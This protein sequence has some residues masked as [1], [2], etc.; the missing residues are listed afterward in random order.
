MLQIPAIVEAKKLGLYVIAVDMNSNAEGFSYA[1]KKIVVSTTDTEKVLEEAKKNKIDG[2]ITI[3]SDRPMTTVAKVAKELDLIGIDEKT[4]INATNKSKMRDALKAYG[5]PIPMYF[6]VEDYDQYIKAID[7]LRNKKY[8]CIVKP[9][10]NSGSRGIRLVEN[11]DID[12]LKK[13]YDYCKKN[14]NSGKL[15]IEEYMQGPEVSVETI[16]RNGTCNVIQITDKLTTGAPY[17]VEMGHNQPSQLPINIIEKIKKVAIDANKAVGIE[18]GPSHTEIKVTKDGPKIVELGAR[19]GGDNITTHLVPYSTGI[20]M[21]EASIKIALGEDVDITKKI[22]MASAARYKKCDIGKIIKITGVD[23][24]NKIQGVK[25][26]KIVHGVGEE[27]RQIKSSNDRV[28]YVISQAENTSKATL[29]CEK[30][31]EKIKIEVEK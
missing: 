14:S 18:N 16:S 24:A 12:Q 22:N 3:A 28:A 19:L 26:V 7:N 11:Y 5:V 27:S 8:K 25:D 21:V 9:A 2:I 31:L 13:I 10:D 30:A 1:D 15:V 6:S 29:Y 4:A 20:N 23:Q 17:F